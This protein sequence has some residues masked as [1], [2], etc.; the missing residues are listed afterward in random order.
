[1]LDIV[2]MAAGLGTRM[3]SE[4][5]K[6]LHKLGGRPVVGH[7]CRTA[8]ALKPDRVIA[9]VG[10]QADAVEEAVRRSLEGFDVP[11]IDFALQ[12]EQLGTGHAVQQA[13]THFSGGTVIVL[14]GDVPLVEAQTLRDL[15]AAHRTGGYAA[16]LLS[17][18]IENPPAYGRIVRG[19]DGDFQRIVEERDATE[20]ERRINEVNAGIYAF[21]AEALEPALARLE[22]GNAQGEYYL[23]DALG[24]LAAEGRR[25][26]VV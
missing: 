12:T 7:V 4:R 11:A 6:V 22:T 5:A 2:I 14:S 20:E 9:V 19:P 18:R 21:E 25:V 3:R 17:T 13:A 26:G 8:A 15:L 16:T 1:M 23:T 10:H 24:L